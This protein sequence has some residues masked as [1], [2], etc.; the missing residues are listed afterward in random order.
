MSSSHI[1][2]TVSDDRLN[3][4]LRSVFDKLD[5]AVVIA[6]LQREIVMVN[7]AA[8]SLF[9]YS[10]E[11]IWGQKTRMLYASPEEFEEQ[12]RQRYN[13]TASETSLYTITYARK[14]GETFEGET[15][16][17][18]IHDEHGKLIYFVG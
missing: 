11:E 5:V 17:G 6:N 18:P 15:Q 1:P 8:E 2:P 9:K 16:G 14:N 13:A 3:P 4:L 12:G 10:E 7:A